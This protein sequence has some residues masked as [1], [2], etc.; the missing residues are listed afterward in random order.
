MPPDNESR[1]PPDNESRASGLLLPFNGVY[2]T[3]GADVFI[4]PTA[5][6]V[7]DVT[8]GDHSSVWFGA[9]IRGDYGPIRIGG[10]CSIQESATVHVFHTDDG[11]VPTILGDD[12]TVG[13]GAVIEG[14]EIGSEVLIGSN[15]VILPHVTIGS[16]SIVAAAALVRGG[17]NVPAGSMIAGVP[18]EV[19]GPVSS[20][21]RLLA[22]FAAR[23]YV[24]LAAQYRKHQ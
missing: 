6:I 9:T 4:A 11:P 5:V 24:E 17:T 18:A 14:C 13:H 22:K 20:K 15:A 19:R 16:R 10:R 21:S 3:I 23:E 1:L 8:V 7:G 12:V 2:P